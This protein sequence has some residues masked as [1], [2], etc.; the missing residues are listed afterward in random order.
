[1]KKAFMILALLSVGTVAHAQCVAEKVGVEIDPKFGSVRVV[2]QYMLNGKNVDVDGV[3]C[4]SCPITSGRY[5]EEQGTL[6]E[7]LALDVQNRNEHCKFLIQTLLTSEQ[8]QQITDAVLAEKKK[9]NEDLKVEMS[10]NIGTKVT[11]TEAVQTYKDLEIKVNAE[12]TLTISDK[13][14]IAEPIK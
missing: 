2:T 9:Q 3:E 4:L 1:M 12:K 14:I 11:V 6:E 7:I 8:K 10:K 5:D 13:S